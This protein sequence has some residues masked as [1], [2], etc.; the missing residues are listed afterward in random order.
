MLWARQQVPGT[1][2]P[3][4]ARGREPR[5]SHPAGASGMQEAHFVPPTETP[6]MQK[7][8]IRTEIVS[9]SRASR[10]G[11]N[12]PRSRAERVA[13]AWSQPCSACYSALPC[14]RNTEGL[15]SAPTDTPLKRQWLLGCELLGFLQT[16][17]SF[18]GCHGSSPFKI[19]SRIEW[20]LTGLGRSADIPTGQSGDGVP[21]PVLILDLFVCKAH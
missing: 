19:H 1:G 8:Q 14:Y 6:G 13:L 18:L 4:G 15:G 9:D 2:E 7:A 21:G 10:L 11:G 5:G 3:W 16:L 20:L 17:G 12:R